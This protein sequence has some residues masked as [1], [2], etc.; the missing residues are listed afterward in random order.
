M[1]FHHSLTLPILP[2]DEVQF[3][4]AFRSSSDPF[5]DNVTTLAEDSGTCVLVQNNDDSRFW[6]STAGDQYYTC[7]DYVCDTTTAFPQLLTS[8]SQQDWTALIQDTDPDDRFCTEE[9]D[10]LTPY[11]CSAIKCIHE[12]PLDTGDV[13]DF[14]FSETADSTMTIS[15]QRSFFSIDYTLDQPYKAPAVLDADLVLTIKKSATSLAASTAAL[16]A[17]FLYT[18]C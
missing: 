9:T 5:I 4:L 12:R 7:T 2:T 8:E 14:Q 18:I 1:R 6:V 10:A 3:E 11:V 15:E 16:T 17:A 13:Y